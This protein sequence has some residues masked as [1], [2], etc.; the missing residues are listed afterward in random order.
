MAEQLVGGRYRLVRELGAGGYAVV[1][2]AEDTAADA[3]RRRVVVKVLNR[4]DEATR[5]KFR[6]EQQ[7]LLRLS[8]EGHP[9][10]CPIHDVGVLE[11]GRPYLVMGYVEGESLAARLK[12]GLPPLT[13]AAAVLEQLGATLSVAH[14]RGVIHRDIKPDNLLLTKEESGDL[15][16]T[17]V[18][19]GIAHV[20][21]AGESR[22]LTQYFDGTLRYVAPEQLERREVVTAA[23]DVY[24][25]AVTAYELLTG[26]CPFELTD[27]RSLSSGA[28]LTERKGGPARP[29]SAYRAEL[30]HG[31]D[32]L[33]LKGLR[34]EPEARPASAEA[35]GRELGAAIRACA[36]GSKTAPVAPA[37]DKD[38][39]A[40]AV[41]G[42]GDPTQPAFLPDA[43]AGAERLSPEEKR[44]RRNL[45]IG[46][47][48]VLLCGATCGLIYWMAMWTTPPPP[49]KKTPNPPPEQL[50]PEQLA[51]ALLCDGEPGGR[52]RE[53][54]EL[55]TGSVFR[56]RLTPRR[57]GYLWVFD[58]GLDERGRTQ[59]FLLFPTP[60]VNGGQARAT[61]GTAV[62]TAPIALT[63]VQPR[64]KPGEQRSHEERLYVVW[65]T[66]QED[67]VV[68]AWRGALA[69]RY[70]VP[71]AAATKLREFLERHAGVTQTEQR[72]DETVARAPEQEKLVHQLRITHRP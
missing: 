19:F 21:E 22:G 53:P 59:F 31:V 33:L 58:E 10:L 57:D 56:L 64:G 61:A 63:G 17:V 14:A 4:L 32:Q 66:R 55:R 37:V 71:Q 52:C 68:A 70:V 65:T 34:Y 49:R 15:R 20:G 40:P 6:E 72:G 18:D 69:N 54:Y 12:R 11:D 46:A 38:K 62:E 5:K 45:M 41:V 44:A 30:S 60:S 23:C 47:A 24:G 51:Y 42:G 7:A 35:Y 36:A 39:T 2:E 25:M 1:Y 43:G 28:L 8:A 26:R 9:G 48:A 67:T 29:A 16:V 50:A 13:E 27:E 3:A